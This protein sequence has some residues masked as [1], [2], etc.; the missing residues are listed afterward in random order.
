MY[1]EK[2]TRLTQPYGSYSAG[3]KGDHGSY[4]GSQTWSPNTTMRKYGCGVV[5]ATD[6]L[7]YTGL[8]QTENEP[9]QRDYV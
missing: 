5:A 4:G 7:L 2:P 3:N 6:F 8:Y 9:D 1:K